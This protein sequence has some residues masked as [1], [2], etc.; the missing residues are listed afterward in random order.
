MSDYGTFQSG[1]VIFPVEASPFVASRTALDPSLSAALA[2]YKAMLETHLGAYFAAMVTDSGVTNLSSSIVAEVVGYDP[3]PYLQSAQYKFPLLAMYRTEEEVSDH[4]VAWYKSESKYVFLY[5]LPPLDAAQANRIVHILKGVK[6]VI[7]DRTIQG[8]D[9]AYLSGAEVWAD[10]GLME[11][12]VKSARYGAIPSLTTNLL[13]PA[14]E[15]TIECTE[16]EKSNPGLDELSGVDT[17]LDVS[18]GTPAD[19]LT[20]SD[21]AWE[22][23]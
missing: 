22:I 17:T 16:R 4:T 5:V 2:F 14:L 7:V 8:Y 10:A 6:S 23:A 9:P 19:D 20:V 11:I 3:T 13:F 21:I 18:N 15:M 12:G 1:G